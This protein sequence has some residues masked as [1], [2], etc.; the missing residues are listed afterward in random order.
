MLRESPISSSSPSLLFSSTSSS[1]F[2]NATVSLLLLL[3]LF[4]IES[5]D[6]L[7]LSLLELHLELL[8]SSLTSKPPSSSSSSESMLIV[9]FYPWCTLSKTL[10]ITYSI[11]HPELSGVPSSLSNRRAK[12]FAIFTL[13][14]VDSAVF[15]KVLPEN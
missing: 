15:F 5:V 9:L 10:R 8:D 13:L 12:E 4:S 11:D 1:S 2:T 3:A 7:A 6:F 14:R